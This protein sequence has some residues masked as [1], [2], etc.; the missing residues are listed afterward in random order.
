MKTHTDRRIAYDVLLAVERGAYA[1]LALKE[2][3]GLYSEAK[4]DFVSALVYTTLDHQITLD[5]YLNAFSEKRIAPPIR[6]LLRLGAAQ[7]LYMDVPSR[8][9]I[10]ETVQLSK[11]VG[12][13]SLSGFINAI[14]RNIDRNQDALPKPKGNKIKQLSV[15]YSYPEFLVERFIQQW[16]EADAEKMMGFSR[17]NQ[18]CI[19][20]N[21]FCL[22]SIELDQALEA[23][24]VS[25][26][27]GLMVEEARYVSEIGNIAKQ[28]LFTSGAFTVQG[29]S[30]ML[31]SHVCAPKEDQ[32]VLD[33]CAAPGGKTAHLAAYMKRGKIDAW[34]IHAHR[35]SLIERNC[36]RLK[37]DFV[38][39]QERDATQFDAT[40]CD[41]YDLILAD[42]PC[43]G[44]GIVSGKPDIR[45][46]KSIDDI[47]ALVEIQRKILDNAAKYVC[48]GGILVY[49]TCTVLEEENQDNI[50][51]FLKKHTNFQ[52]QSFSEDVCSR[53]DPK[54]IQ[55]GQLQLL[56]YLD[57]V[58]GFYIAR[59]VRVR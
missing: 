26:S 35:V 25:F 3:L 38:E 47:K 9:A 56:P 42:V 32:R 40:F 43:S 54:R 14:L 11:Q 4:A 6:C 18:T 44:L 59:M 15:E 58:D 2:Q 55:E 12:K 34:D 10:N 1:N 22:S 49:A 45:Y 23:E 51:W 37:I 33:M 17:K 31:V 52:Y 57:E 36:E 41:Q 46:S 28:P 27:K 8:A 24:N 53:F 21:P 20:A 19:R 39:A 29:E 7:M 50:E 13:G 30:A 48:V 5:F 16:G